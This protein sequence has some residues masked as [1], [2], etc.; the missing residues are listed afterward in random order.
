MSP[1]ILSRIQ[2]GDTAAFHILWPVMSIGIALYMVVMESMWLYTKEESYYRQLRFWTKIFVLTFAIGTASGLPL[3]LEFG[4]NWSQFAQAAGD[5][6]GNI[7]GFETTI[8]F[9]LESAFLA[10]LIFGWKRV[11]P[12]MHLFSTFMVFIGASI[13]AFWIMVANSWMQ[14]PEGITVQNGLIVVTNYSQAI[15]NPD[16]VV[17]FMH[18]MGACVESSLFLIGGIAAW[19]LL[20]TEA[21]PVR[22]FFRQTLVYCLAIALFV[23]PLQV[24]IGDMSGLVVAQYQPEKLA[25]LELQWD[26]NAPGE[27]AAWDVVAWPNS[28]NNGNAFAVSIPNGLSL[29]TTHSMEGT[30]QGL[31][32]FQASDRPSEMEAV[33]TFYGFRLMM[34]IGFLLVALALWSIVLW[35]KGGLSSERIARHRAWLR[36]WVAS[37]PLGFIATEAGWMVREIGRQPWTVYHLMRTAD[38]VSIGLTSYEVGTTTLVVTAAYLVFAGVF[39]YL[40]YRIVRSGPDL[41]S[42]LP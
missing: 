28:T 8:A 3:S 31:N 16:S 25:A 10:I 26:T 36:C 27:G 19:Q 17:S 22:D 23:A 40:S 37:I 20:T 2:F 32:D 30:V 18:M 15:F 38:S 13:S 21:G 1:L 4:T 39:I 29:L 33:I 11:H 34:V 14:V 41:V 7:L 6:M 12:L 5:F 24:V 9:A 35:W 42:P